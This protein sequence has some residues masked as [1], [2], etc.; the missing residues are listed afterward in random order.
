MA[1]VSC[2]QSIY[3]LKNRFTGNLDIGL[4]PV[5]VSEAKMIGKKLREYHFDITYASTLTKAQRTYQIIL[6]IIGQMK[7]SILKNSPLNERIYGKLQ[8]LNKDDTNKKFRTE[9]VA[10]WRRSYA[11]APPEGESLAVTFKRTVSY[12]KLE[13][14]RS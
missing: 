14:N 5:G 6:E 9:Q 13:S 3:N 4:T 8:S 1:L 2:G 7:I 12:Y 11:V 10:I